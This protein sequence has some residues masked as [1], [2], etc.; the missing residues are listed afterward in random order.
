[1]TTN[2]GAGKLI[3]EW[4]KTDKRVEAHYKRRKW[5][6]IGVACL[7]FLLLVYWI[8]NNML[9]LVFRPVTS[10][11]SVPQAQDWA[12]FGRNPLHSGGLNPVS[13]LPDGSIKKVI[14]TGATINSSPVVA[15][16]TVYI[17]SRDHYLYAID[18]ASGL[19]R[20]KF[21][22][23]SWVESSPAVVN[24]VVYSGSNDGNLYALAADNGK[25]I[26]EYSSKFVI[27][28]SPAVADGIV[29]F[30]S[31]DY[32]IHAVNTEN[33]KEIWKVNAGSDVQSSPV[34]A[35]GI[36]YVGTGGEY[37]FA[38]DARHGS[39]RNQFNAYKPV[40]SSPVVKDGVVY[41]CNS[42][43]YLY[44]M[45][46]QSRNWL[47][48]NKIR[49]MWA[50]LYV[51]GGAPKPPVASGYLWSLPL[52]EPSTSS[53][54]IAGTN[55][56]IGAGRKV[57]SVDLQSHEKRWEAVIG[58]TVSSTPLVVGNLVYVTNENG[59][60]Y[61]IDSNTGEKLK[62]IAVGG[63]ITTSPA[64]SGSTVYISSSD[65]NLYAVN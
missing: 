4:G 3:S 41:F 17:G 60:L 51:Y 12:M 32:A 10:L 62:D 48:E 64:I 24:N 44:A 57:V 21:A 19:V 52:G 20:W 42:D 53:P 30:G 47:F 35:D 1:M 38:V 59:H 16:G 11:N 63:S 26:W 36:L 6:I 18:T 27:R 15:D 33:G 45:D 56:F 14:S 25:M 58:G 40:V 50:V 49:P 13:A 65:G 9:G 31:N 39:I 37:F 46:G 61:V 22:T 54:V 8:L 43:G 23:G 29:Y 28:S 5:I 2:T 34:I 55:L 7:V